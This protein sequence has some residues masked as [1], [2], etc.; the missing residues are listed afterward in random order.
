MFRL[1]YNNLTLGQV[2]GIV[3]KAAA[4]VG[5]TAFCKKL[6]GKKLRI[7]LDDS[8][9]KGPVLEYEFTSDTKLVFKEGGGEAVTCD[10]GSYSLKDLTLFS[11]M[12][13]GTMRGY[14]VIIDWKTSVVTAFE[15]WFI[16][17][18]GVVV[19]TS[20]KLISMSDMRELGVFV[21]REVQRQYYFGYVEEA[22][23]TPPEQRAKSRSPLQKSPP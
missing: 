23:K 9:V 13:P 16:E 18:E 22:G 20:E 10:Y 6:S 1:N 19:D 7:V 5:A 3:A 14:N 2:E 15:M 8:P 21:N 4:P 17:Y 11:H 12:I